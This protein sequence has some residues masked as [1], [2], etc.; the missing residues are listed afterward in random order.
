MCSSSTYSTHPVYL[1]T[2][3][4]KCEMTQSISNLLA[5][6]QVCIY[7]LLSS[8]DVHPV[9]ISCSV[10]THSHSSLNC[11]DISTNLRRAWNHTS[12]H[13]GILSTPPGCKVEKSLPRQC[14]PKILPTT[15]SR[16]LYTHLIH[17]PFPPPVPAWLRHCTCRFHR[18]GG[19]SNLKSLTPPCGWA[20]IQ[21]TA[22]LIH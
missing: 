7:E 11:V 17:H 9:A 8:S 10:C 12:T 21:A 14:G 15:L 19:Q 16:L 2:S 22:V 6:F 20:S 3:R 5:S 1:A 13:K 18:F 4:L